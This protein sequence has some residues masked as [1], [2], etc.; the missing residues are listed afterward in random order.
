MC[1]GCFGSLPYCNSE[2]ADAREQDRQ[3]WNELHRL[4]TNA[5]RRAARSAIKDRQR[6]RA[7]L[8]SGLSVLIFL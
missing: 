1:H 8:S 5:L 2:K 4:M 6:I 3:R 7:F